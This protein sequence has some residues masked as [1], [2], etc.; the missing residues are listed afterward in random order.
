MKRYFL[1]GIVVLIP[2]V[3][4][5]WVLRLIV[6]TLDQTLF[7]IP[8][9]YR[10]DALFGVN[11]PGL[12][13]LLALAIVL[14]TGAIAANLLGRRLLQL[15]EVL[16]AR[17]PI[18]SSIYASVKQV[19]DTLFSGSG[20]AF[21]KVLL[22]RYPHANSWTLAFQTG[23]PQGTL[24]ERLGEPHVSV[25]VPTTPNP[26]SGFF[27]M[28]PKSDVIELDIAVDDALKYIISM[29]VVDITGKKTASL[30]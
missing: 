29:G 16:L 4:T 19:S 5:V 2:L 15:G 7:L 11:I 23:F 28:M 1:T 20:H 12:G 9:Q 22:V 30:D 14:V 10:P 24:A 13:V 25:Y 8:A 18:V 21:R 17:I 6:N 3:I 27:L 26:T